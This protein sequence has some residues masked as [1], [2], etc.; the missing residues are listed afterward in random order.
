MVERLPADQSN[1]FYNRRVCDALS[2]NDW[3]TATEMLKRLRELRPGQPVLL[4]KTY[5][6]LLFLYC[7]HQL[8]RRNAHLKAMLDV[9][10]EMIELKRVTSRSFNTALAA[11]SRCRDLPTAR[12]VLQQMVAAQKT[13]GVF[14][15]ANLI[16]C[17]SHGRGNVTMAEAFFDEMVRE[18]LEPSVEVINSMLRVY[19]RSPGRADSM[20]AIVERAMEE[21]AVFPD[22]VSTE[23]LVKYLLRSGELQRAVNY[24]NQVTDATSGRR[25]DDGVWNV[26]LDACRQ[27][28]DWMLAEQTKVLME[29]SYRIA[30]PGK[31]A[32]KVTVQ[33]LRLINEQDSQSPPLAWKSPLF[34]GN[35]VI[36]DRVRRKE[37]LKN[38]DTSAG[39]GTS[40]RLSVQGNA[41][42]D[43]HGSLESSKMELL[44]LAR[45]NR[46]D[47]AAALLDELFFKGHADAS[48]FVDVLAACG[49]TARLELAESILN[50]LKQFCNKTGTRPP[51]A[52]YNTILNCCAVEGNLDKAE[53]Y[54]H[55][56]F[57][58]GCQPDVVT[59]NTMLKVL[60]SSCAVSDSKLNRP[61]EAMALYT[62]CCRDFGVEPDA[63]THFTIFRL[64]TV[65]LEHEPELVVLDDTTHEQILMF[66]NRICSEAPADSLDTGVFNAAIGFFVLIEDMDSV[67]ST[68]NVM[69]ERHVAL[70]DDTSAVVFAT[71]G[72]SG[73]S[74]I[75][76]AFLDFAIENN[77]YE[78]SV[79]VMNGAIRLCASTFN[80]DGALQLFQ[81]MQVSGVLVPNEATYIN[82][83]HACA[84][85]RNVGG[86]LEF[87]SEMAQ[88]FGKCTMDAYNRVLLAC[89][90]SGQAERARAIL[91]R[92]THQEHLIPDVVSYDTVLKAYVAAGSAQTEQTDR[93]ESADEDDLDDDDHENGHEG[94]LHRSLTVEPI[95]GTILSILADMQQYGI[96]PTSEICSRAVSA[97]AVRNDYRGVVDVYDALLVILRGNDVSV[98]ELLGD[99]TLCD[100]IRACRGLN[101]FQRLMELEDQLCEWY[102][103]SKVPVSSRVVLGL[104][105]AFDDANNWRQA[106]RLLRDMNTTFGIDPSVTLFNRV[107]EMCNAAGEYQSVQLIFLTMYNALAY[108]VDPNVESYIQAIYA[109]EQVENWTQATDL[110]VEMQQK[111]PKDEIR[112]ADLRKI[113]LGRNRELVN[114]D[115]PH[116]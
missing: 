23:I 31:S 7:Q 50:R 10:D 82:M 35:E 113:A 68:L 64:F 65:A 70:D 34:D 99:D 79:E 114:Q 110:F 101:D 27:S 89:A 106:L 105:N 33:L 81:K 2:R 73:N 98:S 11:C 51:L 17:C 26:V 42:S 115:N 83:I 116:L 20:L 13:P 72:R 15:Y 39:Y 59:L 8:G 102:S 62:L 71:A 63:I 47:A 48:N 69:A 41:T 84:L 45:T 49:R 111:C 4:T 91:Q 40:L 88:T 87:A 77:S 9:L 25:T 46:V 52:A 53:N 43:T 37:A 109:A 90:L 92:A 86:A 24:L 56:L 60:S 75:G 6:Q 100:Y 93:E 78:P 112:L 58:Q 19:S 1:S 97:C 12:R 76:H 36:S 29:K 107:M 3:I 5:D 80:V 61:V 14:A 38:S 74:E 103:Y 21:F 94:E 96:V 104:M 57:E 22:G 85:A 108:R 28:G 16:N 32:N 30:K 44:K 67:M 55:D 95:G 54:F 66:I 18:G